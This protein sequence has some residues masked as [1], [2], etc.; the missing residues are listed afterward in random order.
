MHRALSFLK[1]ETDTIKHNCLNTYSTIRDKA[2]FR[3]STGKRDKR[4]YRARKGLGMSGR[5]ILH[6]A[7][8][9]YDHMHAKMCSGHVVRR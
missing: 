4:N 8:L 7:N 6:A 3:I 2:A 9:R 5:N 1:R